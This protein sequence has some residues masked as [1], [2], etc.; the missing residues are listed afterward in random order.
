[1]KRVTGIGGIF[2]RSRDPDALKKW[3]VEHLGIPMDDDGFVCFC[4]KDDE[5]A[6][7]AFTVWQPFPEDTDYFDPS[8]KQFMV[9]FR[10]ENLRA[11]LETLR[12][13]GVDVDDRYEEHEYGKF[14]WITDPEG[15]RVELWEPGG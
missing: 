13:E 2:F 12:E 6:K 11:L 15:N 10:V 1:M 5:G 8:E 3:Y 14:G 4:G 9:N 7:E